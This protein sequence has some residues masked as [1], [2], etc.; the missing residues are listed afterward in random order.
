ME[1]T[2]FSN[3]GS[4]EHNEDSCGVAIHGTSYCFVVADGLGGHGGGEVASKIAVDTVCSFFTEHGYSDAFFSTALNMAQKAILLE[5]DKA[6]AISQMKTTIVILV[7]DD[8]QAYWAHVGDSRIYVF[9]NK[10]Y[11]LRTID[12][13]VPQMLALSGEI[14]EYEIR[15]HPDRNRLMRVMGIKGEQPRFDCGKPFKN[16]GFQAFLLCTDGY[17]ELIDEREMECLLRE[18]ATVE[19]WVIGMNRIVQKN[20]AGKDMDNY[21]AIAVWVKKGK[22]F[23]K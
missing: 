20:G 18:C 8:G 7:I 4:R 17:W 6:H 13:S 16:R 10:K 14:A 21:T 1:Y 22:I 23:G 2:S 9:K 15:F 11:K 5:Q 19:E 3:Q 12:H